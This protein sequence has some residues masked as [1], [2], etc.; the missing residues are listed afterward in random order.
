MMQVQLAF[1]DV[2]KK[3]KPLKPCSPRTAPRALQ[4]A[5]AESRHQLELFLLLAGNLLRANDTR[6]YDSMARM[7]TIEHASG[8]RS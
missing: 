7:Y 1:K 2:A 8:L 5:A 6:G 3:L 4:L